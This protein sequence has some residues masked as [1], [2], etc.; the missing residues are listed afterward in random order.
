MFQK[1]QLPEFTEEPPLNEREVGPWKVLPVGNRC[2]S[3]STSRA[4]N[5]KLK[6]TDTTHDLRQQAE[7]NPSERTE[8]PN[9]EN[10]NLI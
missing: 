7:G 2:L 5:I 4:S 8:V 10:K 9:K 1:R 6:R 3:D